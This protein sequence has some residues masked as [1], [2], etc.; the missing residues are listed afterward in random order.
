MFRR[1]FSSG[2]IDYLGLFSGS[3][4]DIKVTLPAKK[5]VYQVGCAGLLARAKAFDFSLKGGALSGRY[6]PIRWRRCPLMC[7]KRLGRA[8]AWTSRPC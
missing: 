8:N 6:S 5:H 7:P 2:P 1:A 3:D 4:R